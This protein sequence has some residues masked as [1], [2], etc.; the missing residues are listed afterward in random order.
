MKAILPAALISLTTSSFVFAADTD[1]TKLIN[2]AKKEGQVYSVGMPDSW[3]NWKG[4]WQDLE[5]EYG[6]KHQDTDMSSA[7]EIAKFAA[8]KSNAT[9][10]IGDVGASFGPVAVQKGVTLPY[11]PT[12]WSQVPDWAKDK[13]GHW[14]LAYTGTIAFMINNELVKDAPKSWDDLLKGKYKVTVGDV[15]I[16]A[17]ANNAVLAAAF[18]RG[19]NENN[20]Q[21]A[22][23][24]FSELAKQKRLSV[25]NPTVANI[26]KGE[27]EVG[28]LW[29]F[30]ALN[31]RDQINRDRFTVIIPS[32]GSVISG[33]TTI[34]NKYAKN[35]NA[36][37]L[38][39]EFIFSDKG[40]INLAE[41]YARPIRA[42][43]ITLPDDIKAKLLPDE[44][45]KNVHPIKDVEGW[46]KSS[47]TLPKIWQ[48]QVLTH[49]Q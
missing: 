19:G 40:Q 46:E 29:D 3:A 45:Y 20:L 1:L 2:A 49:Q 33:Y 36:A 9:A 37:K 38:A 32:D 12:T 23:E 28:I 18:A 48:Q 42:Q 11:K 24:F 30:N 43:H 21:P 31:Y 27:V 41:G 17:Q 5:K 44:Q 15:G 35:P 16:A 6:L 14:A 34:I 13:D 7:Q 39:R 10:D 4:T 8:E 25:N 47:R 26:E 22:I